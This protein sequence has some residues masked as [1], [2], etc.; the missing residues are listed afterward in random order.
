MPSILPEPIESVGAQLGIS[1]RVHDVTVAQEV[2]QCGGYFVTPL[3]WRMFVFVPSRLLGAPQ[4]QHS[5][6]FPRADQGPSNCRSCNWSQ[7][8]GPIYAFRIW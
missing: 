8:G 5:A 7:F 4:W 1:H 2:L 6:L 3:P